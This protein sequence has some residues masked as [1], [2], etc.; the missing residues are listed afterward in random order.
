MF[1]RGPR[2]QPVA[3]EI[4]PPSTSNTRPVTPP[5]SS[6]ASHTT[7]GDTFAGSIASKPK[8][9]LVID[10][11]TPSVIWVRAAG[12]MAF[13]VTPYDCSST[14]ATWVRATMPALAAA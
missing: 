12:A 11:N 13:T 5:D 9:G 6:L 8:S 4:A 10:S 1:S 3:T 2:R 14:A 7:S